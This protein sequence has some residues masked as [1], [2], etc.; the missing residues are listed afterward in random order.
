MT[1]NVGGAISDAVVIR[2]VGNGQ[3]IGMSLGGN[4][5]GNNTLRDTN[6]Q[7]LFINAVN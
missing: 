2:T 6:V 4:W 1:Q 5:S 3:V 7:Q